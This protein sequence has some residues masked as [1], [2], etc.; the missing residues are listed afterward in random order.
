MIEIDGAHGEGG[1]Q[2]LRTSLTLSA[3]TKAPLHIHH[4]RANRS[5]PGL[6]PQHLAAVKA[7][8]KLTDAEFTGA[9]LN[10][11]EVTLVP[12]SL[13]PGRYRF[14]IP[15]AGSLTLLFQTIFLPLSFAGG[16]SEIILTGGTHVSW[17]PLF[18]YLTDQWLSVMHTLGF[19][20]ALTLRKAGFYPPGGGEV[21]AKIL[22]GQGLQPFSCL[23]RGALSR[24]RGLSGVA[25]LKD[26]IA[27]RQKHQALKRLYSVC[28]DTKIQTLQMPSPAKGTFI[29]LTAEFVN[30][31]S[32]C[33][34]ALGAPGKPAEVV[35]DEAVDRL[36]AFL[37]TD[38]C[39]D[40]YL[41][42]QLLLPLSL[43]D[44][45]SSFRTNLVTQ[46][47]LT[48]AHVIR[49]FLPVDIRIDGALNQPGW[50][51]ISG[52]NGASN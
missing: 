10:S 5:K 26:E 11:S 1:G 32:A 30:G 7:I 38:G 28:Q 35:A 47:L 16:T 41:A 43:I 25:N 13:R 46:H 9:H 8:A 19:R 12:A 50:V 51:Q 6:R 34:S 33:Y 24:V 17:S 45:R 42:D 48:N 36:L 3:L 20:G 37:E 2:I 52:T 40:Q 29:L 27:K 14:D 31:G 15:T 21:R 4:I 23:E 44:G 39:V 22:P 18:H 49:Q